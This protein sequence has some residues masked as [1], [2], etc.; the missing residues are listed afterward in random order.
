MM[1]E[2]SERH[3]NEALERLRRNRGFRD[4][5]QRLRFEKG[6]RVLSVIQGGRSYGFVRHNTVEVMYY[7][8]NTRTGLE[9]IPFVPLEELVLIINDFIN[10]VSPMESYEKYRERN[11]SD[12]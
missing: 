2:D 12:E 8:K 9:V 5:I 3:G 7:D 4:E 11:L 6:D 1:S 10:D